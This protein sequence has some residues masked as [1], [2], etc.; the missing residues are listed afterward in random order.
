MENWDRWARAQ[1][2]RGYAIRTETAMAAYAGS[3]KDGVN[4]PSLLIG[5]T[6]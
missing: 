4:L 2:L 6:Q 1:M 5:C 3:I